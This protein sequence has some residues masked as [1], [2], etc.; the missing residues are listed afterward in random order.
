MKTKFTEMMEWFNAIINKAE[1][2][3]ER[4]IELVREKHL[5]IMNINYK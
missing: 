3:S 4:Y 2:G 1:H 5:F